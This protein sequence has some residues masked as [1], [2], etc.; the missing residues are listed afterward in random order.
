MFSDI[1]KEIQQRALIQ[2]YK[3]LHFNVVSSEK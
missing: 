1:S 3:V 2:K